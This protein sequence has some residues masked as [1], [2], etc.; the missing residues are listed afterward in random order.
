MKMFR[1]SSKSHFWN[2]TAGAGIMLLLG[3]CGAK[4]QCGGPA[5]CPSQCD[6][7]YGDCPPKEMLAVSTSYN[8]SHNVSPSYYVVDDYDYEYDDYEP[9]C[10]DASSCDKSSCDD[11]PSCDDASSSKETEQEPPPPEPEPEPPEPCEP[12]YTMTPPDSY[13]GK[14]CI[15]LCYRGRNKCIEDLRRRKETCD[16]YNRMARLEF[17]RCIASGA[18]NCYNSVQGN[19]CTEPDLTQCDS[20]LHYCYKSCGG[21]IT[22]SCEETNSDSS[23]DDSGDM[24]DSGSESSYSDDD[25]SSDSSGYEMKSSDSSCE[26]K[27]TDCDSSRYND[28]YYSAPY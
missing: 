16:H 17:G 26:D 28:G 10:D 12:V 3:G 22:N 19:K 7:A 8:V 21:T 11:Q 20:E 23:Y 18:T 24:S 9:P 6:G 2:L 5:G 1:Q 25:D 13:E 4:I 15:R 14:E 27:P